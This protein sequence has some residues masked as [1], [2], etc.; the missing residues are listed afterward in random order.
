MLFI[1]FL[2]KVYLIRIKYTSRGEKLLI[3]VKS[4]SISVLSEIFFKNI[5]TIN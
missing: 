2:K 1:F 4:A 3:C 5:L